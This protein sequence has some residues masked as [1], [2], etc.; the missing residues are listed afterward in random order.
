MKKM[1]AETLAS[2]S[3]T[4][5][6]ALTGLI[7]KTSS[8]SVLM[9]SCS[10]TL[11]GSSF[12]ICLYPRRS[13]RAALSSSGRRPASTMVKFSREMGAAA[14]M[15]LTAL[16]F[17]APAFIAENREARLAAIVQKYCVTQARSQQKLGDSRVDAPD[18]LRLG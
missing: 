18:R 6:Q 12:P 8:G 2:V 3:A 13:A 7:S 9:I 10:V 5:D 4:A 14:L 11:S 16:I 1:L 15:A 17:E